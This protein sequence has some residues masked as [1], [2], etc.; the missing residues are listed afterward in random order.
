MCN[1]YVVPFCSP[2]FRPEQI[3]HPPRSFRHSDSAILRPLE[4]YF[5]VE[6]NHFPWLETRTPMPWIGRS[7]LGLLWRMNM[8][9]PGGQPLGRGVVFFCFNIHEQKRGIMI[10]L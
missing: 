7:K 9:T 8:M 2:H 10:N 1:V 6:G 3:R 4:A 5:K